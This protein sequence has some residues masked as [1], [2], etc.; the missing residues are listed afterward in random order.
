M[1]LNEG[2]ETKESVKICRI[3]FPLFEGH[4]KWGRRVEQLNQINIHCKKI[5]S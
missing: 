3:K 4:L 5:T 2:M 1:Y